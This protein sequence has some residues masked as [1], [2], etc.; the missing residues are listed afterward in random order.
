M[1]QKNGYVLEFD[2]VNNDYLDFNKTYN[3]PKSSDINFE[4]EFYNYNNVYGGIAKIYSSDNVSSISFY[5]SDTFSNKLGVSIIGSTAG[6]VN[7]G[8]NQ[9]LPEGLVNIKFTNQNEIYFN[10]VFIQ[11]FSSDRVFI[12]P[13]EEINIFKAQ[14]NNYLTSTIVLFS[15]QN[16]KFNLSEGK[17]NTTTGDQGTVATINTSAAQASEYIDSEV[18][19]ESSNKWKSYVK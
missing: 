3:I 16:E 10:N 11:K 15:F 17:G 13:L 1:W 8:T 9:D 18:W 12:S 4:I 19:N 14:S 5:R 2:S 7:F 6:S